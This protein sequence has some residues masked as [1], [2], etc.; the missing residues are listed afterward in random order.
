MS[1][2]DHENAGLDQ[3][4]DPVASRLRS[5]RP[6]LISEVFYAAG[7]AHVRSEIRSTDYDWTELLEEGYDP[8]GNT[9][10]KPVWW[11]IVRRGSTKLYLS[12]FEVARHEVLRAWGHDG[13]LYLD[14]ITGRAPA[15]IETFLETQH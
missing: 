11:R 6:R 4:L 15:R 12:T 10:G 7:V 9:M 8:S 1:P 2:W 13:L 14:P 3:E 5:A